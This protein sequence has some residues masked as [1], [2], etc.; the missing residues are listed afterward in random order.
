M[1]ARQII[2]TIFFFALFAAVHGIGYAQKKQDAF[3]WPKEILAK[4][5]TDRIVMRGIAFQD[6]DQFIMDDLDDL[7]AGRDR[8]RDGLTRG[9][10]LH[11]LDKV[12]RHGER[13]VGFEQRAAPF[14]HGRLQLELGGTEGEQPADLGMAVGSGTDVAIESAGVILAGSDPR[15]VVGVVDLS[16]EE[17]ETPETIVERVR[18]THED[19]WETGSQGWRSRISEGGIHFG[20]S[21]TA[22]IF[23]SPVQRKPSRPTDIG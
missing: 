11:R 2:Q 10:F 6:V 3:D 5:K 15:N 16:T 17:V 9:L 14:N 13:D 20:Q 1:K 7:L 4:D 18:R 8:F 23:F 22:E 12:A 21:R 19:G